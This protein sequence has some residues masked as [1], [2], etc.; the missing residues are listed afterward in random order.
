MKDEWLKKM[1][2]YERG[3]LSPEEEKAFEDELEKLEAYQ[4][5]I[6]NQTPEERKTRS[7]S[8]EAKLSKSVRKGKWRALLSNAFSA[9][10][11]FM[12]I[13]MVSA[14][15][16]SIY[17]GA[18]SK[19]VQRDVTR[20]V[21]ATQYPNIR[22]NSSGFSSGFYFNA[23]LDGQLVKSFGS[24]EEDV[25]TFH[26]KNILDLWG[27]G[28]LD[29][30]G[31]EHA[32]INTFFDPSVSNVESDWGTL[33]R[34]PEG[35]LS[36]V[37]VTLAAP[38]SLDEVFQHLEPLETIY[39]QWYA[40]DVGETDEFSR[41]EPI[42]FPDD[43]FILDYLPAPESETMTEEKTGWFSSTGSSSSSRGIE[44]YGDEEVRIDIFK[45]MLRVVANN[46]RLVKNLTNHFAV[47][48]EDA[49][50]YVN[51]NGV[52]IYGLVLTGPT[53][54]LLKLQEETWVKHLRVNDS[55][56]WK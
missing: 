30:Y 34:L 24:Y 21:F 27:I 9:F 19:E 37:Y 49:L 7:N 48:S 42:G 32:P 11:L 16:T 56:L 52:Q 40:V 3:E 23:T 29:F 8:S 26:I 50:A 43:P 15:L 10:A 46:Q 38:K 55:I 13:T 28:S 33:E 45:E 35:T 1:Q 12:L 5:H 14:I 39:P 31:T 6:E 44:V 47:S 20:S 17:Y 53:K 4:S 2:A 25:G 54:E 51:E 22:M 41:S 18:F 36:E